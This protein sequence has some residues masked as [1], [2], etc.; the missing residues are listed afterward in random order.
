MNPLLMNDL[1]YCIVDYLTFEQIVKYELVSKHHLKM[2][3]QHGW[4]H[5][6]KNWQ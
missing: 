6:L 2:I 1:F 3:R 4:C 5:S